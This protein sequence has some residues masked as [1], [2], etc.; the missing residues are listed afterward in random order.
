M[1]MKDDSTTMITWGGY[2]Y[3][4]D[5]GDNET[6]TRENEWP[7]RERP[8]SD[9]KTRCRVQKCSAQ[10][11]PLIYFGDRSIFIMASNPLKP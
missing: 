2:A 1:G 3:M 10:M 7:K 4:A 8:E 5:V 9:L 11:V 6:M